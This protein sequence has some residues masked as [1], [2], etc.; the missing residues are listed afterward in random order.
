MTNS[1]YLIMENNFMFNFL[2]ILF[3]TVTLNLKIW[4][5]KNRYYLTLAIIRKFLRKFLQFHQFFRTPRKKCREE[6]WLQQKER[7]LIFPFKHLS[8]SH[9]CLSNTSSTIALIFVCTERKK[10][11]INKEK[12]RE[13]SFNFEINTKLMAAINSG[14]SVG[15]FII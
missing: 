8:Q 2:R 3:I 9:V 11:K 6:K 13:N 1:L 5:S 7:I 15:S 12:E 4:I 14:S 10:I